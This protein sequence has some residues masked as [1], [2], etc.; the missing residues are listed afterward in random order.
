M[1]AFVGN[2]VEAPGVQNVRMT[3]QRIYAYPTG[4]M[5]LSFAASILLLTT[6]AQAVRQLAFGKPA[7]ELIR[8][9]RFTPWVG[10]A[11]PMGGYN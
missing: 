4:S 8:F 9:R 6:T 7:Q 2:D 5:S 1:K 11:Q 3:E 10:T